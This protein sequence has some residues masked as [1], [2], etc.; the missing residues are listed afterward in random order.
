MNIEI[1]SGIKLFVFFFIL[2][3][4]IKELRKLLS[5]LLDATRRQAVEIWKSFMMLLEKFSY[6][7]VKILYPAA[8][9]IKLVK[10]KL[11]VNVLAA[12]L[13]KIFCR[14]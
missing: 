11:A 6:S 3:T 5:S 7:I 1:R 12:F 14:S 4:F 9:A 2:S 13:R 8:V 10:L